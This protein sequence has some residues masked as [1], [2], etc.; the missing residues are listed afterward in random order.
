VSVP[1]GLDAAFWDQARRFRAQHCAGSYRL[2]ADG[3]HVA[4]CWRGTARQPPSIT[5][6]RH[7]DDLVTYQLPLA[8][9]V[10]LDEARRMAATWGP[11]APYEARRDPRHPKAPTRDGHMPCVVASGE[12]LVVTY[13]AP[14]LMV[15][16]S[17][18]PVL[19]R[20]ALAMPPLVKADCGKL[21]TCLVE[22]YG[23]RQR[24]ALWG[25]IH[26]VGCDQ[27]LAEPSALYYSLVKLP[28]RPSP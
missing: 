20:Q 27:K 6:Y 17:D 24:G 1:A 13:R 26:S 14:T 18:G 15:Q 8:S 7:R 3:E 23:N 22:V 25:G 10:E 21:P 28:Q 11:L 19:A 9:P 16:Q 4:G 5:V 12:G 2:I